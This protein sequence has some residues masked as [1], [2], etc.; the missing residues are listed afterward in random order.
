MLRS[1]RLR[2]P[3]PYLPPGRVWQLS[4]PRELGAIR[5]L[6]PVFGR[7]CGVLTLDHVKLEGVPIVGREVGQREVVERAC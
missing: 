6:Q 2:R 1:R 5:V 7:P 3:P 4:E